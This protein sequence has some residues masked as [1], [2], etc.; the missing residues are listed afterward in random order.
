MLEQLFYIQDYDGTFG[1]NSCT[2]ARN[3]SNIRGAASNFDLAKNNAG[4]VFIYVDAT[5]GW[6]VYIDGSDSDASNT[7]ICASGGTEYNLW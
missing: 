4:A 1:T 7:F 3:G 6:Q 2:V 5:E